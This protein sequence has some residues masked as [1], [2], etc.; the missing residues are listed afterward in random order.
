MINTTIHS[1]GLTQSHALREEGDKLEMRIHA[2]LDS[3]SVAAGGD[4]PFP[5]V[6]PAQS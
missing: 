4:G 1:M 6:A 2:G 3:F 5:P